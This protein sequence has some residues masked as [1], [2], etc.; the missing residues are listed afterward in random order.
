MPLSDRSVVPLSAA[1]V[2]L[3]LEGR[4][5]VA[6]APT[7]PLHLRRHGRRKTSILSHSFETLSNASVLVRQD[8]RPV[9]ATDPWLSGTC[10]FGSWALDHPLSE[11]QLADM[12]AAEY[13]WISHGH[14][15]H[16][17]HDSLATLPRGAKM[18]LPDHY[19][20]EI[21]DSLRGAG[22]AVT[23]LQYRQWMRLSDGIR[24]MCIDNMNQDGVLL[25]EAGDSLI[26]NLNDS[27]LCGEA[28][29]IRRL[30]GRYDRAKTYMLALCAIDADMFNFVDASTLR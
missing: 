9:L 6:F 8:G 25:I 11:A 19:H 15:D 27:P 24:V 14:P 1:A 2:T 21:A 26:V 4:N 20:P 22:F 30:V 13:Y 17:H 16:L 12:R 28:R 3:S 29:F 7:G 10:Y 18:L 23:I 5:D